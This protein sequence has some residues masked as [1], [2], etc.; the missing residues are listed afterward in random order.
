MYYVYIYV[1]F[2]VINV[3]KLFLLGDQPASSPRAVWNPCKI[4][5]AL[6]TLG[7]NTSFGT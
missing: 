3:S 7:E 5:K 6:N 2:I 1:V 4:K